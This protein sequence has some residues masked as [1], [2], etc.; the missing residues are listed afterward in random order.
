[1]VQRPPP[2]PPLRHCPVCGVAMQATKT[3]DH[4]DYF[5]R[6]N[7]LNCHTTIDAAP[8]RPKR[9]PPAGET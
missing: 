5:D 7:C 2:R 1:M 6:F 3:R 8:L 9:T 4:L